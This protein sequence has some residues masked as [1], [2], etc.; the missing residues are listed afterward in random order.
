MRPGLEEGELQM[1]KEKNKQLMTIEGDTDVGDIEGENDG[2]DGISLEGSIENAPKLTRVIVR[3]RRQGRG[4]LTRN[5]EST[6]LECEGFGRE[7]KKRAIEGV[8]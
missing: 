2:I 5:H 3:K 4:K 6:L 1:E 8:N 7:E